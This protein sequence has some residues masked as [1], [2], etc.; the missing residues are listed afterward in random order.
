MKVYF[1]F[2]VATML[3]SL[4]SGCATPPTY[5]QPKPLLSEKY[6]LSGLDLGPSM[7]PASKLGWRD[8]FLDPQLQSVIA[9]TLENNRDVRVAMARV[10]EARALYGIQRADQ[11]PTIS[12]GAQAS[13]SRVP[14]DLSITGS[15]LISSQYQAT[16]N[17]STWELDFW[18]RVRNLKEAALESYLASTE[19]ARA[20]RISLVAQVANLYLLEREL[21]ERLATAHQALLSRGEAHRIMSRRYQVGATSKLDA[22]QTELLLNQARAELTVL[23]RQREQAHNAL[24]LVVGTPQPSDPHPLSKVEAGFVQD[25]TPGLPSDL[26]LDRPDVLAAEHGLKAAHANIAAARAA[27]FPRISLTAGL[28]TGSAELSGLFG[29]DSQ[30]WNFV[31]SLSLPLFD[32]GRIRANVDLTEARKVRAVAVY[33]QTVQG[34]FREVADALADR[35]WLARQVEVQRDNLATQTERVRLS[36]L[37]YLN[38]AAA[39][40]EVLDAERDRFAAEQALAQTR[41]TLLASAV[42]LYAALGGG[43][44]NNNEQKREAQ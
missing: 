5:E 41:R 33:E 11:L 20:I 21:D 13:R 39:Y 24:T 15:S 26:L 43:D 37:R 2:A 3:P 31:P 18:G 4:L 6:N 29:S 17:L 22:T 36:E 25:I 30:V 10:Q 44:G 28:G 40:L 16:L 32:A 14:A 12:A 9:Q 34:A 27:F 35:R 7:S 19:A 23:E 42:N 1:L 8:Y 38:G